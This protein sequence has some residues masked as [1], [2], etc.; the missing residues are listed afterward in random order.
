MQLLWLRNW[1]SRSSSQIPDSSLPSELEGRAWPIWGSQ[2]DQK[3]RA[4]RERL[5]QLGSGWLRGAAGAQTHV[6]KF[7][8]P[9]GWDRKP[10]RLA[11]TVTP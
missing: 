2:S 1:D 10:I 5:A 8:G 9:A 7:S 11:P 4:D 3:G 6:P